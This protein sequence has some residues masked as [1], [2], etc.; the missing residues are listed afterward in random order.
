MKGGSAGSTGSG[1]PSLNKDSLIEIMK[2]EYKLDFQEPPLN[3]IFETKNLLT[4]DKKG[5]Y[6]PMFK[7]LLTSLVRFNISEL[8]INVEDV[9]EKLMAESNSRLEESAKL[10]SDN[11][12]YPDDE[13]PPKGIVSGNP[14]VIRDKRKSP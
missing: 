10:L 1:G 5:V 11:S 8:N 2:T 9:L 6:L 14:L 3:E 13:L 7:R 4:E 12:G